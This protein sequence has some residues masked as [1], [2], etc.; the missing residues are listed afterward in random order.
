MAF[1]RFFNNNYSRDTIQT[2]KALAMLMRK[3]DGN[4]I[5]ICSLFKYAN[6]IFNVNITWRLNQQILTSCASNLP[7]DHWRLLNNHRLPIYKYPSPH[8]VRMWQKLALMQGDH[9]LKYGTRTK[10]PQSLRPLW[11]YRRQFPWP[12]ANSMKNEP[13]QNRNHT[14]K[15]KQ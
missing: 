3:Y 2:W 14:S 9:C 8:V 5:F 10:I 1:L 13:L 7:V 4:F 11:R 6:F 15:P 12:V